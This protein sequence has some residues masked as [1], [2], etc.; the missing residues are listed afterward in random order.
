MLKSNRLTIIA[1]SIVLISSCLQLLYS[2]TPISRT[3]QRRTLNK[4][5]E[6][7]ESDYALLRNLLTDEKWQEADKKTKESM[8]AL[9][10]IATKTY[11]INN[12]IQDFSCSHLKTIDSLWVEYSGGQFGLSVQNSI[13]LET[14]NNYEQ[15]NYEAYKRFTDRIGWRREGQWLSFEDIKYDISA[16]AGHLPLGGSQIYVEQDKNTVGSRF[17]YP[18]YDSLPGKP[19]YQNCLYAAVSEQN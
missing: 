6:T 5:R 16:P 13:Y 14:G 3:L 12:E 15:W 7:A 8:G 17:I 9:Q 2:D 4:F 10:E 19:S 18:Q 11:Y 1:C